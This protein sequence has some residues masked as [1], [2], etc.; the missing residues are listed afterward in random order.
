MFLNKG[1]LN[2]LM[3][4]LSIASG[5]GPRFLSLVLLWWYCGYS[6]RS[7]C[8]AIREVSWAVA[9]LSGMSERVGCDAFILGMR[10][11]SRAYSFFIGC[12]IAIFSG[13]DGGDILSAPF[14]R[15]SGALFVLPRSL[16]VL[17]LL[18]RRFLSPMRRVR[19]TRV[20]R[21]CVH[22]VLFRLS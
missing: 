4:G 22:G 17:L 1:L 10:P 6:A 14:C 12:G 2:G 7:L 5:G 15:P 20:L 11:C 13:A 9:C 8:I 19:P 16:V 18:L 21:V 3:A